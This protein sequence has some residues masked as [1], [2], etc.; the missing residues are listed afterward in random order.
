MDEDEREHEHLRVMLVDDHQ[1]IRSIMSGF[2]RDL[3]IRR[4]AEASNGE[5]ALQRLK[6]F[7][8][9]VVFTD[10]KMAPIDGLE[11]TRRIRA[12]DN[13]IDPR[14]PIVMVT[15][16]TDVDVVQAARDAGIN[17]LLAKPLSGDLVQKRV[18]A[19]LEKPRPFV[20]TETYFGPDRRRRRLPVEGPDRRRS[21]YSYT[22]PVRRN[23]RDD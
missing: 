5:S 9:D 15:A 10:L 18:Q 16:Y 19:V 8:A 20:E 14:T 22:A 6:E 7:R 21:D 11:L 17:E 12:G 1:P 13:G 23:S 4:I 2:L 3:G